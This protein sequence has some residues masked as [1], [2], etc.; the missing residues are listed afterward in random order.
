MYERLYYVNLVNKIK[1]KLVGIQ[2]IVNKILNEFKR[3]CFENI[4]DCGLLT[5]P[6]LES[7]TRNWGVETYS[8]IARV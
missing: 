7:C 8:S 3:I 5:K 6:T 1:T 2:E 4:E